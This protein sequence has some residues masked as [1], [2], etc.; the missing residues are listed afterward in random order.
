MIKQLLKRTFVYRWYRSRKENRYQ[1]RK[2][3]A[4][5]AFNR[6]AVDVL[7]LFS[8]ALFKEGIEFWLDFGTLLGY[9]REHDFIPHDYD[10]DTGAWYKD[11][12]Q[13][14]EAL[15]KAGFEL[16]RYYYLNNQDGMEECYKHKNFQTTIDI[17]YFMSD[18]EKTFCFSFNPLVSMTKK[19][20]L[21]RPQKS[22]VRKWSFDRFNISLTEFKGVRVYVPTDTANHLAS[23]YGASFMTPIPD[24]P[25]EG[26]PNMTEYTYAEMPATAYLKIGYF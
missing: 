1:E 9:Y 24:F 8:N 3:Q 12:E 13:I 22:R 25:V 2:K 23:T 6:E 26:R 5:E 19:R 10:L 16:V 7:S 21:N 18:G 17:L 15:E 14:K 4:N 11:H 20:H